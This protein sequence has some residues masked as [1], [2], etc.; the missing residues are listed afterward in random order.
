MSG[1][2]RILIVEDDLELL[3]LFRMALSVRATDFEIVTATSSGSAVS[4]ARDLLPDLILLDIMLPGD[5]DGIEICRQLHF[6]PATRGVG[7]VMVSALDDPT[8]HRSAIEAGAID[9][10]TKPISIRGLQDRVRNVLKLKHGSDIRPAAGFVAAT[11][12]VAEQSKTTTPAPAT[13]NRPGLDSIL[14]ALQKTL[15]ELEPE[16]WKE[17]LV[18]AETRLAYKQRAKASNDLSRSTTNHSSLSSG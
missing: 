2:I 16:D 18:L 4:L 6:D 15:A 8:T 10:W 5:I 11:G 7:V 1:K 3:N 12:F 14:A 9:Y 17:I 13:K